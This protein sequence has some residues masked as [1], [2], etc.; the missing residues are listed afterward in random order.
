[1]TGQELVSGAGMCFPATW[2][3]LQRAQAAWPLSLIIVEC[4]LGLL[5]VAPLPLDL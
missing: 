5:L 3:A 1:M 2:T 4:L